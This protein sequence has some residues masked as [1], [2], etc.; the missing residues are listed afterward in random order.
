MA[1]TY[2]AA[3]IFL[4]ILAWEDGQTAYRYPILPPC[5]YGSYF[6]RIP[7]TGIYDMY[8]QYSGMR[9]VP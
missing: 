5:V 3:Y 4:A 7:N 1:R 2:F 9:Y 6:L 8:L